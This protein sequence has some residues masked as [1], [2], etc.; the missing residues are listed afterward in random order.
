MIVSEVGR[1]TRGSSSSSPPPWVTTAS[2]GE[3]PATCDFSFSMKLRGISSGKR[4]IHMSC[5]L[6][7]AVQSSSDVFPQRPAIGSHNHTAAN[8]SIVG[9]LGLQYNLVVPLRKIFRACWQF[10]IRHRFLGSFLRRM[11]GEREGMRS[12]QHDKR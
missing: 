7:T 2:S 8:R 9:E 6:K 3:N 10:L 11:R 4:R 1:I 12:H 5:G